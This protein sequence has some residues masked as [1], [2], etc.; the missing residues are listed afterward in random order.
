MSSDRPRPL[1][2]VRVL[3]DEQAPAWLDQSLKAAA[4]D[5]A[6][7]A[8]QKGAPSL[9]VQLRSP[10]W[11]TGVRGA[12]LAIAG[13]LASL[14]LAVMLVTGRQTPTETTTSE[15]GTIETKKRDVVAAPAAPAAATSAPTATSPAATEAPAAAA[16]AVSEATK[17]STAPVSSA[18]SAVNAESDT[19]ARRAAKA[20]RQRTSAA[21]APAI[22]GGVS[23][24]QAGMSKA[25]AKNPAPSEA[26]GRDKS[27]IA[28][29]AVAERAV[30]ER[31]VAERAVAESARA[32]APVPPAAAKAR[33]NGDT[34]RVDSDVA[35]GESALAATTLPESAAQCIA[36]VQS[37]L[38]RE[39]QAEA[40]MLY[41]RCSERFTSID[42][43]AAMRLRFVEPATAPR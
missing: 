17:P 32:E 20:S 23:G 14:L 34:Y 33:A 2:I 39:R 35:R 10:S 28:D 7:L 25:E 5:Q 40:H 9:P 38:G 21:D 11:L 29:T 24:P 31:A 8:A 3:T 13:S 41:R 30:A 37:L 18:Q 4:L 16:A 27:A 22:A 15:A 1:G 43:P 42:W 12:W 6:K 26:D 36:A 19:V